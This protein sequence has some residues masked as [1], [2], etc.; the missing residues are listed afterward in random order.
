MKTPDILA[1]DFD[2]VI[3]DGRREYFQSGWLTY[4]QI[5]HDSNRIPPEGLGDRY[6]RLA[7]VIETDLDVPLL[8]RALM[9]D[10]SDEQILHNWQDIIPQILE[11]DKIDQ[12]ILYAE[13]AR[14]R[15]EWIEQ[16]FENWMTYQPFYPGVTERLEKILAS[17]VQLV[18][19][20]NRMQ[21]FALKLLQAQGIT[22]PAANVFGKQGDRPKYQVIREL[23]AQRNPTIWFVEDHVRALYLVEEQPNLADVSLFLGD[24]GFNTPAVRNKIRESDSRIRIISLAQFTQDFT[25]WDA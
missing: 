25:A 4:R 8:V 7:P 10:L 2:G 9:L 14:L 13:F 15:D 12:E 21:R 24:W 23:S 5:W 17:Q 22:L 18:I 16:D 20:T 6:I 19:I 3:C 1:L 11:K